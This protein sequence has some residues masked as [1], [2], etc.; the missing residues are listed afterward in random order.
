METNSWNITEI[1][2]IQFHCFKSLCSKT[3]KQTNKQTIPPVVWNIGA[4][5]E[6]WQIEQ[7][8]AQ[9]EEVSVRTPL[10]QGTSG[11]KAYPRSQQE[12]GKIHYK[13]RH[14]VL[15][16]G[17]TQGCDINTRFITAE[18]EPGSFRAAEIRD[19]AHQTCFPRKTQGLQASPRK[20][21]LIMVQDL[22]TFTEYNFCLAALCLDF[23]PLQR[24]SNS[25]S[26]L[27]IFFI[28]RQKF[29]QNQD[30]KIQSDGNEFS[31]FS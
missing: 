2:S 18:L 17:W 13:V 27:N 19:G 30:I 20:K 16:P 9:A 26:W 1:C 6:S 21:S 15:A 7:S 28:L 3:N 14:G 11:T 10:S 25:S 29:E 5:Q 24:I 23:F 31:I 8:P 4:F 12:Q 22:F